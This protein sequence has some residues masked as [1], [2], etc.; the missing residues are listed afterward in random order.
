MV[1]NELKRTK[2]TS[3]SKKLVKNNFFLSLTIKEINLNSKTDSPIVIKRQLWT[4]FSKFSEGQKSGA[5]W[6]DGAKWVGAKWVD[7][8]Y[9]FIG[10]DGSV[11][12][13]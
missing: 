12:S 8:L 4:F 11:S 1:I 10:L 2:I 3:E 13:L 5:K 7:A 9:V 6:V